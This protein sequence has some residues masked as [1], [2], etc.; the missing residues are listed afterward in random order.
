MFF[1]HLNFPQKK[2]TIIIDSRISESPEA[3]CGI[4][5]HE[6][7]CNY[8]MRGNRKLVTGVAVFL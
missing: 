5:E 8:I 6:E 3:I 7:T 2:K 4:N 1:F